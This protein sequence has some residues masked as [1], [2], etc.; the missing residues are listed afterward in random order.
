MPQLILYPYLSPQLIW[1]FIMDPGCL[2]GA[3]VHV[4]TASW[5]EI[6]EYPCRKT[7]RTDARGD[8][9]AGSRAAMIAMITMI[10][11]IAAATQR[12]AGRL[13]MENEKDRVR[14]REGKKERYR[15][16]GIF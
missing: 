4:M 16:K 2:R 9:P 14:H 6:V 1:I 12:A 13:G 3:W 11:M 8:A 15:I 7:S 10:A 5:M